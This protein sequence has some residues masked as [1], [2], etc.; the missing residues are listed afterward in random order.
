MRFRPAHPGIDNLMPYSGGKPIGELAREKN[1]PRI[2]KLAS[3]ENPLGASPKALEAARKAVEEVHRYPDGAHWELK[4]KLSHHLGIPREMIVVGN[5]SNEILEL[6]TQIFLSEGGHSLYAWPTFVVYRLAALAHGGEVV[7]IPMDESLRFDLGR[8]AEAITQR[9]RLIF[10]SNPNNPTG[11]IVTSSEVR[12]FME[13]IPEGVPFVLDEAYFEFARHVPEFPDGMDFLREGWPV[14]V[15][16]TFSKIYGLAG[17][18]VGYAAVPEEIARLIEK[19]RQPFNVNHVSQA[20]A[21]AA[22][23]D[24]EFVERTLTHNRVEMARIQEAVEGMG[25]S[26]TPS[27]TNFLLIDLAGRDGQDVYNRLLEKGIIV[28]PMA[29][30]GLPG[31]IRVTPGLVSENDLFLEALEDILEG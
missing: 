31:T 17:L 19:V 16:R 1:L 22:L 6:M 10:V 18:R 21:I 24:E 25:L 27:F 23:D 7:E 29:A 20:A 28:R 11:T 13:K 26:V 5:G 30:Y 14:V 4:E 2:I 9:T 3:N 15:V 12:T 8:L